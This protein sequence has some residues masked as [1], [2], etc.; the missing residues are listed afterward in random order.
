MSI[1]Q[2]KIEISLAREALNRAELA[3]TGPPPA[4]AVLVRA[5][6]NLQAALDRGGIIELESG[7]TFA[8]RYQL[9]TDT[10]LRGAA[11]LVGIGG[12]ALRLETGARAVSIDGLTLE[13]DSMAVCDLGDNDDRQTTLADVPESVIVRRVTIPAH[14]G[15]RGLSVHATQVLIEDCTI[16][17]VYDPNRT[18][19][20]AIYILNTPGGVQITG[21]RLS[22]GS[23]VILVGGDTPRIPGLV[24]AGL[25]VNDCELFRPA[26]WQTDGINRAVKNLFELKI[27]HDVTVRTCNLHG[28]WAAAQQGEAF[29]LTPTRGGNVQRV[30]LEG[31]EI[32]DVG[33]GINLIGLAYDAPTP[34]RTSDIDVANNHF[35]ISRQTHGGR[36]QLLTAGGGPGRVSFIGNQVVCDGTSTIYYYEGSV[37]ATDG[38]DTHVPGG[39]MGA[40]EVIGNEMTLGKYGFNLGGVPNA[41]QWEASVESMVVT[42]NRFTGPSTMQKVFPDNVYTA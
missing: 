4:T 42:D 21:C 41:A 24:P 40:L 13:S 18:D 14:R 29:M 27:G 12:S 28:C 39:K 25:L 5:G 11:R 7:A 20:Q 3:L 38:T 9:R 16:L 35:R 17:D 32:W 2:A 23:E 8:G 19:S 30:R 22:A 33:S 36:G 6:D 37:H 15:R 31:N 10:A 26:S 34:A 1:E